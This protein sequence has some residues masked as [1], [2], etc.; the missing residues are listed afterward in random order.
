MSVI[1]EVQAGL[2]AL[3]ARARATTA[4]ITGAVNGTLAALTTTDKT[5][6]VAAI[7]EVRAAAV[8]TFGAHSDVDVTTQTPADGDVLTRKDGLWQ[9]LANDTAPLALFAKENVATQRLRSTNTGLQPD[10]VITDASNFL[11]Q[12][13]IQ[14]HKVDMSGTTSTTDWNALG[15]DLQSTTAGTNKDIRVMVRCSSIGA[16]E[17]VG[18]QLVR[19]RATVDTILDA[20]V[21]F[22]GAANTVGGV[23]FRT[24]EDIQVNDIYSIRFNTRQDTTIK[25]W[26]WE[27]QVT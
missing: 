6:V 2:D 5:S 19:T 27:F 25:I 9:P 21:C 1:T 17:D 24:R 20:D 12:S 26:R 22:L 3:I 16:A 15:N 13:D 11:I 4:M 10:V 7:N 8:G 18:F 23:E 14:P